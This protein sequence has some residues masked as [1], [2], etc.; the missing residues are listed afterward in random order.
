MALGAL[1]AAAV[2]VTPQL[3][4]CS[5]I[6]RLDRPRTPAAARS[7]KAPGW[8]RLFW[9]GTG[10]W[11]PGRPLSHPTPRVAAG[12]DKDWT[13]VGLDGGGE[14]KGA[15][16]AD[17]RPLLLPKAI[18]YLLGGPTGLPAGGRGLSST[19]RLI[20]HRASNASAYA[21]IAESLIPARL[22]IE[23]H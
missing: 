7:E 20:S 23:R 5:R 6:T 22:P 10:D 1:D 19:V 8:R 16:R 2:V 9:P 21:E 15:A 4:L 12:V 14:R 11:P 13:T 17:G 18:G 3:T